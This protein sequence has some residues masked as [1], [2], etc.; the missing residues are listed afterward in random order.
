MKYSAVLFD[1][2]DTLCNTTASKPRVFEMIRADNPKL[3]SLPTNKL[4][5][6]FSQERLEYLKKAS[7]FQTFARVE[8]WLAIVRKLDILVTVRELKKMIDDYWKYSLAELSLFNGV[9]DTLDE[10][11]RKGILT[12]VLASSDFYSKAGKLIKLDIDHLFDYVFTSDLLKIPKS[13]PE[14]YKYVANYLK[15]EPQEMLMVGDDPLFDIRPANIA[16][17][18]TAQAMISEK[19]QI[20]S[21]GYDRPNFIIY[22]MSGILDIIGS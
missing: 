1:I 15:K 9:K 2:D 14:V 19:K 17:F 18:T 6:L 4:I 8:L 13:S 22:Q 7:G 20:P 3:Q 10:I 11:R 16:G 21:K 5:Q 12:G